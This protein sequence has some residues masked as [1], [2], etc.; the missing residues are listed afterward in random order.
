MVRAGG[1]RGYAVGRRGAT[2]SQRRLC[3]P[4]EAACKAY[5]LTRFAACAHPRPADLQHTLHESYIIL[6]NQ[7]MPVWIFVRSVRCMYTVYCTTCRVVRYNALAHP[8]PS[9]LW[10]TQYDFYLLLSMLS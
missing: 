2:K 9:G 10:H 4:E 5:A 3:V 8:P 7:I 1:G 6:F